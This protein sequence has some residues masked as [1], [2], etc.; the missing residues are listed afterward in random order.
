MAARVVLVTG[1]ST[2]IGR[3]IASDIS[4]HGWTVFGTSRNP[5][6]AEPI[7][8]V[9]FLPLDVRSDD[10]VRTCVDAVLSRR[11]T[12]DALVNNAGESMHGAIEESS[13]EE[14]KALFDTNFFGVVRMTR[15]VLPAMRRQRGGRIVNI[16]SISGV[17]AAP[18][19]GFYSASKWAIE[20]Y[21]ESLR[22]EVWPFGIRVV[23]VEPG[24]IRTDIAR[25]AARTAVRLPEY[26]RYRR[27]AGESTE[28]NVSR[29]SD[30]S[31]VAGC[32]LRVLDHPNPR[33]RYRV[34]A[35]SGA[36]RLRRILPASMF[37]RGVRRYFGLSG[38]RM[39]PPGEA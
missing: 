36:A 4:H 16:S 27:R 30:P 17:I 20:G 7:P 32:V 12:I 37:E 11:G 34:G 39:E 5:A 15:A 38:E 21:S 26:D 3:A 22:H 8:G 13:M 24:W 6:K 19:I 9:D 29:G 33:L 1:A 10:S 2:G 28:G 18:F 31:V 14:A 23:I 25:H 35:A